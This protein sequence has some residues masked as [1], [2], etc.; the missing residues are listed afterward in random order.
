MKSLINNILLSLIVAIC[1]TLGACAERQPGQAPDQLNGSNTSQ[2]QAESTGKPTVTQ[3]DDPKQAQSGTNADKGD[4]DQKGAEPTDAAA[5]G[6]NATTQKANPI[7]SLSKE[8]SS[9]QSNTKDL[10]TEVK[11]LSEKSDTNHLY[12]IIT[13]IIA[14]IGLAIAIIN[15][16][17]I[18]SNFKELSIRINRHRQE[19]DNLKLQ[20][21]NQLSNSNS[22][23]SH[24]STDLQQ[25][26]QR[27]ATL[28]G[29]LYAVKRGV[30]QSTATSTSAP[31][32][33]P[34]P[35]QHSQHAFFPAPAVNGQY[36]YFPKLLST[37]EM[38]FFEA[39]VI[40]SKATFRP[41]VSLQ[42]ITSNDSLN[43]AIEFEGVSKAEAKGM[44]VRTD[45]QAEFKGGKWY[46]TRKVAIRL[47]K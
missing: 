15:Y 25:L 1:L 5:P 36:L 46:V 7:D 2:E 40:G 26:K 47:T 22:S 39:E 17:T 12:V 32:P 43:N 41:C 18:R 21:N 24:A 3:T 4:A 9:V 27:V 16:V 11:K 44:V 20:F 14:I 30:A 13:F 8:L 23:I 34:T 38:A 29:Q 45:G 28:E 37:R 35:K 10:P 19:I 31:T 42:N 6:D 33:A